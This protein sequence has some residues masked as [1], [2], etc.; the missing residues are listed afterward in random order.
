MNDP[1]RVGLLASP[2]GDERCVNSNTF[3]LYM[4]VFCINTYRSDTIL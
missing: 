2:E 1:F 4:Q 3:L